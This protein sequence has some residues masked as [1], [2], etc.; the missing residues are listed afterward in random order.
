MLKFRNAETLEGFS[1]RFSLLGSLI[2][3]ILGVF[4]LKYIPLESV[5]DTN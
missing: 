4:A 2:T 1:I 3:T 5:L